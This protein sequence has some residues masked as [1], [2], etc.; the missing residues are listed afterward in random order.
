M[1]GY[2]IQNPIHIL[3]HGGPG[4]GKSFLTRC[5]NNAAQ[6]MEY[7][8]MCVA[9]TGI[10]A[11]NLPNGRTIHNHFNFTISD[12][13][14]STFVPDLSTDKLNQLRSR[15]T[16]SK[17]IL[18]VIDEISYISPE[19]LG[20]I[21]NRLRQLMGKPE[22]PFG[23]LAVLLMG[24][25]YQ[26]PPVAEPY[27]L[28]SATMKLLV[29]RKE[30][31]NG[32]PGPRTRGA[33]LFSQ[34]RKFELFQQ[35]RAADDATHTAMLNQMRTPD[36]GCRYI[37][38]EHLASI[39]ILTTNDIQEDNLWQWAP[40]VVTSNKERVLINNSQSKCWALQKKTPRFIWEI[41]L[42]GDLA[43][44]ITPTIHHH[45]YKNIPA[46]KGCFVAGAPG[47]I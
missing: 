3:V 41:P 45:I 7:S 47:N 1:H 11:A 26:L 30:I 20:Q 31:E 23:G 39:K 5:I 21:D 43:S 18:L 37:N 35:M 8:I 4:T 42:V 19:A 27:N 12:L 15:L 16:T 25:F 40:V 46:L 17:L 9:F 38:S 33:L 24:D 6:D 22:S 29:D 44:S 28:Y 34:F 13:K 14:K 32:D 36:P 10:A 2:E